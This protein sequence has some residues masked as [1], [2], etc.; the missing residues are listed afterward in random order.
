GSEIAMQIGIMVAMAVVTW[1]LGPVG[2]VGMVL[3]A[4]SVAAG[5]FAQAVATVC[6]MEGAGN[7]TT[8]FI[9]QVGLSAA[10][11][12]GAG[13]LLSPASAAANGAVQ[14]TQTSVQQLSVL[15]QIAEGIKTAWESLKSALSNVSFSTVKSAVTSLLAVARAAVNVL[16]S[17]LTSTFNVILG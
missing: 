7:K 3:T 12:A 10:I 15:A 13:A 17:P 11:T 16:V 1:A 5:Q 9:L 8:G 6:M 4:L 2:A 14:G